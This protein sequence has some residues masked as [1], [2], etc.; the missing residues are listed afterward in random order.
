MLDQQ[1]DALARTVCPHD[2]RTHAQRRADAVDALTV[3]SMACLCGREDCPATGNQVPTGQYVI[4]VIAGQDSLDA[5]TPTDAPAA[6]G[7]ATTFESRGPAEES[8]APTQPAAP[9]EAEAEVEVEVVERDPI[10]PVQGGEPAPAASAAPPAE[11]VAFQE[12]AAGPPN[13][14]RPAPTSP[15]PALIPG[16]G[17]I[18]ADQLHDLLPCATIRP[19]TDA[20]KLGAEHGYHPSRAL[21]EFVGCR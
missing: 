8:A 19:V 2:P 12:D 7:N 6:E 4:H 10:T 3:G 5:A 9:V 18:T 14:A 11:A 13:P 20:T 15:R 21:T 17:P 1:L 16:Y